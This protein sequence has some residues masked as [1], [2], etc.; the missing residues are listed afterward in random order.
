MFLFVN[1]TL[2]FTS[3]DEEC[4]FSTS[5]VINVETL[6]A[7]NAVDGEKTTFDNLVPRYQKSRHLRCL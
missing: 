7:V 2:L 1:L 3:N 5:Y 6:T 4:V